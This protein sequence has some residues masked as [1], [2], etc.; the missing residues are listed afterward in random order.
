LILLS[1]LQY[2]KEKIGK[3]EERKK[4]KREE[5]RKKRKKGR[6]GGREEGRKERKATKPQRNH[7]CGFPHVQWSVSNLLW[8]ILQFY[9]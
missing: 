5:R 4:E 2:V 1:N 6:N 9:I 8:I 3:K 7:C